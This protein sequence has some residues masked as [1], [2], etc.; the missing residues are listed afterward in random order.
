MTSF[1]HDSRHLA[2]TYD[3]VSDSQFERGKRLFERLGLAGQGGQAG[4]QRVLDVGSGTGRLAQWMAERLGA[5]G[6][7]AGVDPLAERVAIARARSGGIRFEVGQAEDLGMFEDASFDAVCMSSVLH[8]VSDKP[9]A[10][11][12]IRRVL[13]PG[14]RFGATTFP[15]ELSR[16]GDMARVFEAILTRAPYA[17]HVDLSV[18][19]FAQRGLSSTATIE[20]LAASGFE[21]LELHVTQRARKHTS[22]EDVVDFLDASSFGNFLRIVPEALQPQLRTDV[23]AALQA[24]RAPEGIFVRDWGLLF[25]AT[26]SPATSAA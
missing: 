11:A 10:F 4:G 12:E 15:Q 26:R 22:G 16:A 18:L 5:T 7:V 25:V 9:K 24:K 17:G 14:G 3:R 21:L 19:P 20:L 2:E 23:V 1:A 8:W 6:Q 13:R